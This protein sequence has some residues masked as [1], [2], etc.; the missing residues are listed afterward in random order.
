MSAR[1][2]CMKRSEPE[3]PCDAFPG[4]ADGV[5]LPP[6]SSAS[7]WGLALLV[8]VSGCASGHERGEDAGADVG[9]DAALTPDTTDAWM[10]D[11]GPCADRDEDGVCDAVDVCPDV[12]DR[13]RSMSMAMAWAGS[14]TPSR[15]SVSISML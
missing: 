11:A 14:A 8:L 5:W 12:A 15:S 1:V 13:R 6:M 2:S 10:G 9:T 4:V 3:S 7:R